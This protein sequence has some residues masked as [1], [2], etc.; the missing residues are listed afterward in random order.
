MSSIDD[1][2]V[3]LQAAAEKTSQTAGKLHE[4]HEDIEQIRIDV[5]TAEGE[6]G[7][8]ERL[9]EV[10]GML[11]QL[12]DEVDSVINRLEGTLNVIND[13]IAHLHRIGQG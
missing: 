6:P 3:A 5:A 11:N 10:Q 1:A 4:S 2:I 8:S 7:T 13:H 12:L 9:G